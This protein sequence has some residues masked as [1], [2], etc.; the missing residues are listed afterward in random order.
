MTFRY[1]RHTRDLKKIE[2]FYTDIV[3]LEKTGSF[4]NHENYHG[5]FLGLKN[6][7]WQLEFTTSE[8]EPNQIT[9]DDDILVFYV[10]SEME[11]DFIKQKIKS[12]DIAI[13]KPENPYW[14]KNGIMI[15]DPDGFRIVFSIR[16]LHFTSNDDLT[17]LVRNRNIHNWSELLNFVKELPYGRNQNRHDLSLVLKDN[18]GSCS[19]KHAFV[20]KIADMNY[21]EN[22]QLMLGMYKMNHLN[23][24]KIGRI[25]ADS[26]L[27]YI[28]EA[29][30]YLK[31]NNRR[32]DLTTKDAGIGNIANYLM[33]EFEIT[34]DQVDTFKVE[35]HR[36]FL[37]KWVNEQNVKWDAQQI[38]EVREK[39][40]KNFS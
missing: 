30:C 2:K 3:G 5:I 16:H 28:P 14:Q 24:P 15:S 19:S 35:Y 37:E 7:D 1:A 32:I 4:E 9:D 12:C 10:N 40:I 26:G 21:F 11:L 18:K 17:N 33:E 22:I 31:M 27:D 38:W 6:R 34:P 36:N 23:T 13:K 25:I 20:K 8:D 39:C 29:H